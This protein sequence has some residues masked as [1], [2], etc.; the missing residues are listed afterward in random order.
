MMRNT[1]VSDLSRFCVDDPW[2]EMC[3]SADPMPWLFAPEYE[4]LGHRSFKPLC[5][6]MSDIHSARHS[7][8]D[9]D[10][11]VSAD[12]LGYLMKGDGS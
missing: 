9:E 6:M 3:V 11:C 5:L 4:W 10:K 7:R 1:A 2:V 8:S 12:V